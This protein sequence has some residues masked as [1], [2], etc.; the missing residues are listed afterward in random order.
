MTFTSIKKRNG[1]VVD[2]EPERI[3]VAI[4]KAS[5]SVDG[6]IA[7]G[8][9]P[10]IVDEVIS[11]LETVI[12]DSVP[13]VETIQDLVEQELMRADYFKTARSYILYREEHKALRE[14][15]A[16]RSAE[17][18]EHNA[19]KVTL[20]DGSIDHFSYTRL[21]KNLVDA[22][23]GLEDSVDIDELAQ[24]TKSSLYD[25]ITLDELQDALIMAASSSIEK[26]SA[27]ST[28]AARLLRQKIYREVLGT[29]TDSEL[30]EAYKT[31][32][33]NFI[34]Q[35]VKDGRLDKR[36][37][38]FDLEDLAGYLQPERD[39]L[40]DYMGLDM[41]HDRYFVQNEGRGIRLET[42]P[43]ILDANCYG[44]ISY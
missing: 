40:F 21:I 42:P 5:D 31:A 30:E 14:Q 3:V 41:M 15:E 13:E 35:T 29:D 18:L 8:V 44:V 43:N 27:Y 23:E 16:E 22:A 26:D 34:T 33:Q 19:L 1:Q 12:G 24:L 7:G 36:L 10:T 9:I 6:E 11:H 38:E 37:L 2:F 4:Q 25:G 17:K 39:G 20:P 28:L 32:F